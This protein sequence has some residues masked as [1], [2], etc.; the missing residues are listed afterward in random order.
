MERCLASAGVVAFDATGAGDFVATAAG[1]FAPRSHHAPPARTMSKAAIPAASGASEERFFGATACWRRGLRLR[2]DADLQRIDP[3]R[4][5][6]VLELGRAE[7]GD[8]QIEP[9]FDLAIGVLGETDRAG[10]GDALRAAR[11]C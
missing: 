10:L 8:R 1:R 5:G 2:R 9:A 4:L 7:I 11:R 3:D 6:D